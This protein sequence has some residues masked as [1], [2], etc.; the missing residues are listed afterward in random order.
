VR[1]RLEDA[2][3]LVVWLSRDAQPEPAQVRKEDRA[4]EQGNAG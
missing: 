4:N 3:K 1:P 2:F